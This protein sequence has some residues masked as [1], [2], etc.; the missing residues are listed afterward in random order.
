[1][2]LFYTT[3]IHQTEA[4]LS[5][6]ESAHAIKVLRMNLNDDLVFTDGMGG[7]FEASIMNAASSG[8]ILQL[9]KV[10]RFEKDTADLTIAIAPTK[11]RDRFEWFI[12]KAVEFGC[13]EIQPIWCDHSERKHA[14]EDRWEKISIAAMKQSL[15]LF[16]ADI[17]QPRGFAEMLEM[18][19]NRKGFIAYIGDV[20]S[21]DFYEAYDPKEPSIIAI[22][23]EGDFSEEEVKLAVKAGW[24]V[25][26]LGSY[27]LRTESAG[28]A[29]VMQANTKLA[30]LK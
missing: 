14:R 18:Y 22:G 30:T 12:E 19:P 28:I 16:K 21:Q 11:N 29:V 15:H 7:L 26:S 24:T 27:R 20:E 25:V 17:H 10:D 8:C 2:Q 3:E 1:M 13:T 9:H 4:L 5:P 6:E 23:P